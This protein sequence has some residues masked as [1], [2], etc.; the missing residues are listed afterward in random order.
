MSQLCKIVY[1]YVICFFCICICLGFSLKIN[2][3]QK[4]INFLNT[5][6]FVYLFQRALNPDD[7]E[8]KSYYIVMF[9]LALVHLRYTSFCLERVEHLTDTKKDDTVSDP[10]E[11]IKETDKLYMER[12]KDKDNIVED[13]DTMKFS[14]IDAFVYIFYFPLFFTG[15][16]M[17]YNE[18]L[19]QVCKF[20]NCG[21]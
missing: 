5:F 14:L 2:K 15:P 13:V 3:L 4:K 8:G 7:P 11:D 17:T 10:H 20:M 19:K 12:E 9:T 18:F 6:L 16:I 1:A 21:G